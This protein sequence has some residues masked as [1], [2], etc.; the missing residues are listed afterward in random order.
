MK[1]ILNFFTN[2]NSWHVPR[3]NFFTVPSPLAKPFCFT[4]A[5]FWILYE[6][7]YLLPTSSPVTFWPSTMVNDPIPGEN[8][9]NNK[10]EIIS[11]WEDCEIMSIFMQKIVMK[12]YTLGWFHPQLVHVYADRAE[13]RNTTSHYNNTNW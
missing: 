4:S 2:L 11:R 1:C 7:T 3:C 9:N 5:K 10:K 12:I 8:N 13:K 6:K